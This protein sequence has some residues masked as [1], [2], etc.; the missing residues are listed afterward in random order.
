MIDL[1]FGEESAGARAQA[2]DRAELLVSLAVLVG[3]EPALA[4]AARTIGADAL[5]A[6]APYLQ[7]L[8]LSAATRKQASKK[9]LRELRDGIAAATGEEPA[10]LERLRAGPGPHAG[11]DR[12][13]VG[14]V[15][16][17]APAARRRRRQRRRDR[18]RQLVVAGRCAS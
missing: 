17:A 8:A 2:I 9:V 1:G 16:R 6:A 3:P 15:L 12:R 14:R 13:A 4:S 10:P 11:H 18:V 7:P 5:A